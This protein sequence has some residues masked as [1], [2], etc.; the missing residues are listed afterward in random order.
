MSCNP[1]TYCNNR[2]YYPTVTTS[3]YVTPK[4]PVTRLVYDGTNVHT[5]PPLSNNDYSFFWHRDTNVNNDTAPGIPNQSHYTCTIT[6]LTPPYCSSTASTSTGVVGGTPCSQLTLVQR[7][8]FD[9]CNK[10]ISFNV[11][12]ATSDIVWDVSGH[13]CGPLSYSGQYNDTVTIPVNNAGNYTVIASIT[14]QPCY[15]G[16]ASFAVDFLPNF[17]LENHCTYITIV[18]KSTYTDTNKFMT[19]SVNNTTMGTYRVNKDTINYYTGNGGTFDFKLT[20]YDLQTFSIPCNIGSE[21]ITNSAGSNVTIT[22]ANTYNQSTTCTNTP[23]ELTA[24]IAPPHTVVSTHWEFGD[25]NT[26]L[27]TVGV[28]VYHTFED[29]S[30]AYKI[31][32]TV[33]DEN[34]CESKDSID[35]T[36]E[37][38]PLEKASID[39]A[40]D[41]YPICQGV[42]LNIEYQANGSPVSSTAYYD[43]TGTGAFNQPSIYTVYNTNSYK[44]SAINDNYCSAKANKY[45]SFFNLPT[46]NITPKKYNHC[47]GETIELHGEP[48]DQASYTYDWTIYNTTTQ[49]QETNNDPYAGTLKFPA[50]SQG[51]NYII[52]LIVKDAHGCKSSAATQTLLVSGPFAAPNINFGN[53]RCIHES[54]VNLVSDKSTTQWS[55]TNI[56]YNAYYYYPGVAMAWYYDYLSGCRSDTVTLRIPEAPDFDALLTGCYKICEQDAYK[57]LPVYGLLPYWQDFDWYWHINNLCI[58]QGTSNNGQNLLLPLA[59]L[60]YY[61]MKVKYFDGCDVDS[62]QLV[63][64]QADRCKCDG[65]DIDCQINSC[66]DKNC[67]LMYDLAV[68]V[69]NHSGRTRCLKRLIPLY[70]T[71]AGNINITSS[72]FAPVTLTAN[73]CT[74]FYLTL[75]VARLMPTTA[76]FKIIDDDCDDCEAD[77]SIDLTPDVACTTDSTA[78]VFTPHPSLSGGGI[79]YYDFSRVLYGVTEVLAVWSAPASVI[80]YNYNTSTGILTGLCAFNL[81]EGANGSDACLYILVCTTDGFCV[82]RYCQYVPTYRQEPRDKRGSGTRQE[83]ADAPQLK[84]NP[85]TGMVGVVSD[86][87]VTEVLVMDMKGRQMAAFSNTTSFNVA[88]LATGT[89]IVRIKSRHGA[90]ATERITYLKLVKQ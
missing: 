8:A 25:N 65:L 24:A 48:G 33:I 28:S 40:S 56:G 63:I 81:G 73:N 34:G 88:N 67:R 21:T 90:N 77:F 86:D 38:N 39:I 70:D 53:P 11:V 74:T 78:Y 60:G 37:T 47:V 16:Y 83:T 89:Y 62:R 52:D 57:Q 23:I 84:P 6:S 45:V 80:N 18:N 36:S 19:L 7:R 79:Y 68:T 1:Y 87:E 26:F 2:D 4:P 58:D 64:K 43:W 50:G 30:T 75:S 85:A 49:A 31:K 10:T 51:C 55:N 76:A 61:H 46:A 35:I 20:G 72:T 27:D 13:E 9:Y 42:P 44:V 15:R 14:G 54:S 22:T 59:G 82:R 69:C 41:E 12:G 5:V 3:V 66:Y 29:R 17:A 32:V 71:L